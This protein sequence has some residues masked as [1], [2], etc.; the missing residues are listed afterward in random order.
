MTTLETT[1]PVALVGGAAAV[2]LADVFRGVAAIAS[3]DPARW[4]MTG[5]Q[6]AAN[7][8]TLTLSATDSYRAIVATVTVNGCGTLAEPVTI[9]AK[10][11]RD[12]V[13]TVKGKRFGGTLSLTFGGDHVAVTCG[14]ATFA[15][16]TVGGTFPNLAPLFD[17]ATEPVHGDYNGATFDPSLLSGLLDA[18]ATVTGDEPARLVSIASLRAARWQAS[19]MT[20]GVAVDALVMPQRTVG[21]R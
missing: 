20:R 19:N 3:N 13:R 15:V 8:D 21:S 17:G 2:N 1:G 4:A 6:V 5:V 10:A 18:M 12:A 11:I 9:D 16:P 7:G 14:G